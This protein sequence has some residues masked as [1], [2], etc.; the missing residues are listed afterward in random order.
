M[1]RY[2]I[3]VSL[4]PWEKRGVTRTWLFGEGR[5]DPNVVE[6]NLRPGQLNAEKGDGMIEGEGSERGRGRG[7][8]GERETQTQTHKIRKANHMSSYGGNSSPSQTK[9]RRTSKCLATFNT[10]DDT[11]YASGRA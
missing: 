11:A 3:K 5:I 6:M 4:S 9:H 10:A 2:K 8:E 1:G 7:R